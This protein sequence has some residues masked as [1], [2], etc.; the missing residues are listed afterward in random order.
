MSLITDLYKSI[1]ER[2]PST[3]RIFRNLEEFFLKGLEP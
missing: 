3:R 2:Y 1:L